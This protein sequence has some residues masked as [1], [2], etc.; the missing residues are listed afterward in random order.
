MSKRAL[1]PR[2]AVMFGAV[3]AGAFRSLVLLAAGLCAVGNAAADD[4]V[5]HARHLFELLDSEPP[6]RMTVGMKDAYVAGFNSEVLIRLG[7]D[8]ESTFRMALRPGFEF[9]AT[10]SETVMLGPGKF[11]S[12]GF[13]PW[14]WNSSFQFFVDG[15]SAAGVIEFGPRRFTVT[16]LPGAGPGLFQIAEMGDMPGCGCAPAQTVPAEMV[17]LVDQPPVAHDDGSIVDV[18]VVYTPRART[19]AGGVS[20]MNTRINSAVLNTNTAYTNS[21]V[22]FRIR[23]VH[24]AEVNY[25]ESM[26]M[27]QAL[28]DVTAVNSI[29]PTVHTLRNQYGADMVALITDQPQSPFCG[30]AWLMQTESASFDRWAFSVTRVDCLLNVTFVHELGHNMGLVHDLQNSSGPGARPYSYGHRFDAGNSTFRTIMAY[31]PGTSLNIHSNPDRSHQGVP[32]GTAALQNTVRSLN[33]TANTVANWRQS[34]G[35]AP[36]INSPLTASGTVGTP[37]SYAITATNAPISYGATGLP[38]GLTVNSATG[39]ITGTPTAA[40][41]FNVTL[42]ATNASGTGTATLVLTISPQVLPPVI[43]SVLTANGFVGQP[44]TYNI[45]ATNSP[46]LYGATGL[47]AGLTVNT[48][49]GAITGTPTAPGV[50]SVTITAANS[51]G[52][53]ARTLV[54][55]ITVPVQP[56]V[57]TSL[58]TASGTAGLPFIY[59]IEATNSPTSYAATGLPNGISVDTSTGVISGVPT[60]PGSFSSSITATNSAGFDTRNLIITIA[61]PP[62][63]PQNPP[64]INSP[65][66]A[67][68]LVGSP[69]AY[70]ITATNNP[71][72]FGATSLPAGLTLNSATGVITGTPTQAGLA[73]VTISA[74]N[75]AGTGSRNLGINVTTGGPP[76][77]LPPVVTSPLTYVGTRNAAVAY[78]ITATSDP[79]SFNAVGLPLGVKVNAANGQ[80]WGTPTNF[81]TFNV[82]ISATNP[83][84]TGSASLV[85]TI[86]DAPPCGCAVACVLDA[87]RQ[88]VQGT[89]PQLRIAWP[90]QELLGSLRVFRDNVL[91]ATPEGRALVDAYYGHSCELATLVVL[92]AKL[93]TDT[94][95]L[96]TDLQPALAAADA[97]GTATISQEEWH[98]GWDLIHRIREK[99]SPELAAD[100]DR[101][102]QFLK[103]HH[104]ADGAVHHLALRPGPV[105]AIGLP[106]Q[107]GVLPAVA[108]FGLTAVLSL[109]GWRLVRRRRN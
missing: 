80:I 109:T 4:L 54:I 95:K 66:T 23:L 41:T 13:L 28:E 29:M 53:D 96:L 52:N 106:A 67:Q 76:V 58:L 75:M 18:L 30:I 104:E 92:D 62:P 21:G 91:Q 42:S 51:A 97:S 65:T 2:Y 10:V 64:V 46:T 81:G 70:I 8:A 6:A 63:P 33:E 71:T 15:E 107:S 82:T 74:T 55:T 99:A 93:L 20:A 69:F 83:Q 37:F 78:N 61:S 47:P 34:V 12:R 17:P 88:Y 26:D 59:E 16:E 77:N 49:T 19:A 44:F 56:P 3:M 84:G 94:Q 22:N 87:A 14:V 39:A 79:V 103:A 90:L 86:S 1:Q 101:L 35:A 73:T 27:V 102:S 108:L 9:D 72:S 38:S 7:T 45:V 32:T 89:L 11:T 68:A 43:T 36:V 50:T 57:I 24:T 25:D 105:P 48:S 100:L 85:M 98:R 40:G 60:G 31:Q 5:P